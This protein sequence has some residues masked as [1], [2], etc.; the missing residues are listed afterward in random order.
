LS[1][2]I[3]NCIVDESGSLVDPYIHD[4]SLIRIE[5]D[6]DIKFYF[7]PASSK[8][9]VICLHMINAKEFVCNGLRAGNIVLD[10]TLSTGQEIGESAMNTLFESGNFSNPK[11]QEYFRN[12]NEDLVREEL[13]LV[14]LNPSFGCSFVAICE[15]VH[16]KK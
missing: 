8:N 4:A 16:F 3:V 14:T 13:I 5:F 11:F 1:N 6:K 12:L 10:V 2:K 7:N 15:T 9:E